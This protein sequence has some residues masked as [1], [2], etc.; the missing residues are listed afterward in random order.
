MQCLYT[1]KREVEN[2]SWST[3]RARRI[4]IL[5]LVKGN[6]N[7]LSKL[8]QT[9]V[10]KYTYR[11]IYIYKYTYSFLFVHSCMVSI[12]FSFSRMYRSQSQGGTVAAKLKVAYKSVSREA[13]RKDKTRRRIKG[14]RRL[15]PAQQAND[16]R[17][18]GLFLASLT[19]MLLLPTLLWLLRN[20]WMRVRNFFTVAFS[21]Y[22]RIV[23]SRILNCWHLFC[24]EIPRTLNSRTFMKNLHHQAIN[25]MSECVINQ[26]CCHNIK[27][28]ITW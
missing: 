7:H 14:S 5:Y 27:S 19:D 16:M 4:S 21:A 17:S 24:P 12:P 1:V 22:V 11:Y 25:S 18:G 20:F 26:I 6:T 10:Y 13:H 28:S 8:H 3:D 9:P 23:I 15:A 2:G